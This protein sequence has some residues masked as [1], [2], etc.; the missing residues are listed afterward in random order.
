MHEEYFVMCA[1]TSDVG[2]AVGAEVG[3]A[4]GEPVGVSVGASVDA[5]GVHSPSAF[6]SSFVFAPV[7]HVPSAPPVMIALLQPH[8]SVQSLPHL[9]SLHASGSGVPASS[10]ETNAV[11]RNAAKSTLNALLLDILFSFS[12]PRKRRG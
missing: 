5:T 8:A 10:A 2:A 6:S 9:M 12:S 4:V 7:M 3:A 1:Q 11:A